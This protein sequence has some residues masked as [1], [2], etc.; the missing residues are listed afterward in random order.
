M[1]WRNEGRSI[2][3]VVE[4]TAIDCCGLKTVIEVRAIG[5]SYA[6]Q[7]QDE[8][9]PDLDVAKLHAI[10]MRGVKLEKAIKKLGARPTP[11]IMK[12][13]ERWSK[14]YGSLTPLLLHPKLTDIYVGESVK[15]RHSDYGLVSVDVEIN[16]EDTY[17]L[18]RRVGHRC[19]TPITA[20]QPMASTTDDEYGVRISTTI[21]PVGGPAIHIRIMPRTPWT[22]PLLVTGGMLN[23]RS[24][25]VL[26]QLFED[27]VPILIVGPIG[28]GKTSLANAVAFMGN[29]SLFTALIMD[30]DEMNLPNHLVYKLMERKAFGLGV[31]SITKDDLIAQALRMGVD[32]IVVNEVIT[33]EEAVA[34]INAVTSGHGGVTTFHAGSAA[35]AARRLSIIAPGVVDHLGEVAMVET[36]IVDVMDEGGGIATN[37]RMRIVKSIVHGHD[38]NVDAVAAKAE[39]IRSL[40][41]YDADSVIRAVMNYYSIPSASRGGG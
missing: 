1:L 39:I 29:P 40:A 20:Y 28:S 36:G 9:V 33:G 18:L 37:K 38:I 41:G 3:I 4:S 11:S 15:A 8:D 17:Y 10:S 19:R 34:W 35:D 30:V 26:W 5:S 13:Y 7:L 21:P 14:H 23:A 25:A 22:L 24:A 16:Q 6:I 32:H 2:G 12:A 31:K 27:K